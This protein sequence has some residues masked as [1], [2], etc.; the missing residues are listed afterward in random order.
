MGWIAAG[1]QYDNERGLHGGT[2][3]SGEKLAAQAS[4]AQW[5][6]TSGATQS[7]QI[8]QEQ[9]KEVALKHAGCAQDQV[10]LLRV[11]LD[12]EDGVPVYEERGRVIRPLF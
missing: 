1:C 6:N 5:S 9:A 11:H 10:Q 4:M 12:E 3:T 8:T 7:T 2:G